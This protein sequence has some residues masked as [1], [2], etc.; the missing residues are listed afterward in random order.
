VRGGREVELSVRL[1]RFDISI[2]PFIKRTYSCVGVKRGGLP[3]ITE[4]AKRV[5]L[6]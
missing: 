4:D 3:K 1:T 2:H 5:R 6:Y